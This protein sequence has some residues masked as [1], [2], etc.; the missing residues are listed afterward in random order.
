L[1]PRE[2]RP[3]EKVNLAIGM[4]DVCFRVCAG[5]IKDQHPTI[6]EEELLK[7][8]RERVMFSKGRR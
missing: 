2:L 8:V 6:G 1:S 4:T 5:A 3:D 7:R